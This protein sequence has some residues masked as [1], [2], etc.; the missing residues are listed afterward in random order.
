[1]ILCTDQ[2]MA[3]KCKPLRL[4]VYISLNFL[5]DLHDFWYTL[6][7]FCSDTSVNSSLYWTNL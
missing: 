7:L 5:T 3:K 4:T 2:K 1:V 6:T